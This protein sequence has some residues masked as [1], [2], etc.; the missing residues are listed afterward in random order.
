MR[1]ARKIALALV[2][3]TFVSSLLI[4]TTLFYFYDRFELSILNQTATRDLSLMLSLAEQNPAS[5]PEIRGRLFY[6]VRKEQISSLSAP[7]QTLEPGIYHEIEIAGRDYHVAVRDTDTGRAYL[8]LD[9]ETIETAE[10]FTFLAFLA[11][12]VL[13]SLLTAASAVML[14]RRMLNP[15]GDLAKQ[16]QNLDPGKR[17]IRIAEKYGGLEVSQIAQAFDRFYARLDDY[18]TREQSFTA[19]A[20]HEFRTPLAVI[21]TSAEILENDTA[22]SDVSKT[23]LQKIKRAAL[24]M[25]ELVDTLLFL[26]RETEPDSIH[27]ITENTHLSNLLAEIVEEQRPLIETKQVTLEAEIPPG[28]TLPARESHLRIIINNLINNAATHT[29]RGKIRIRLDRE[30][31]EVADTGRGIKPEEIPHI[32]EKNFSRHFKQGIGFGLYI[33]R[34][35]CDR[36]NWKINVESR[37]GEGACFHVCFRS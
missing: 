10:D 36:Y 7:L 25:S 4:I 37:Y 18:I 35:I 13:I 6:L 8:A 21:L 22:L 27:T 19:A 24:Q 26:A 31:L 15:V 11:G 30:K 29:T 3:L 28:I 17:N 32:F 9:I 12:I 16:V 23:A 5:I 1:L 2:G 33:C 20:S 14:T 34:Q